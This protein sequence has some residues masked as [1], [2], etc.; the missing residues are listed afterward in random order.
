MRSIILATVLATAASPTTG[1]A[2]HLT[3]AGRAETTDAG[4]G[5]DTVVRGLDETAQFRID[6]AATA[7]LLPKIILP[8]LGKRKGWLAVRDLRVGDAEIEGR[9][10]YGWTASAKF[11]IDRVRGVATVDGPAGTFSGQCQPYDP[12]APATPLF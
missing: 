7:V 10:P 4:I 5:G 1:A 2:L 11:K 6:G 12:S 8:G 3:C 9:I